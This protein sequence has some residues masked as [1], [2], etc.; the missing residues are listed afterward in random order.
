MST[1][2]LSHYDPAVEEVKKALALA[3]SSGAVP[4]LIETLKSALQL[5]ELREDFA[6]NATSKESAALKGILDETYSHDWDSVHQQGKS[7]WKLSPIMMSGPLEG[8][9]L[10]SL[11]SIQK[12]KRVLDIGLFT[13]YSAVSMAEALPADGEVVSLEIDEYLKP[14]VENLIKD[15][16]HH[17]KV[18]IITGKALDALKNLDADGEKFDVVFLDADKAEYL[19]YFKVLVPIRDGVLIIRRVSDV[20][21]SV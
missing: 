16:P 4:E 1:H 5:V 15:S 17:K 6:H 3:E 10:K 14:L 11:V 13:G 7:L 18:R 19:D 9:F 20:E 21:G 12:A 8:Q 2:D